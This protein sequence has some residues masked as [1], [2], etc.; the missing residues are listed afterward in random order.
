MF[1]EGAGRE[2]DAGG[3]A[4]PG[5]QP[6]HQTLVD[7]SPH[8]HDGGQSSAVSQSREGRRQMGLEVGEGRVADR[9]V[10][11]AG[12]RQQILNLAPVYTRPRRRSEQ[13]VE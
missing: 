2:A 8:R 13:P 12:A 7:H 5:A 4:P 11:P 10:E 1:G 9:D 3:D 6:A